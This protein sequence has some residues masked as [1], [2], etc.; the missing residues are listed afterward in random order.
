MAFFSYTVQ[1]TI[2]GNFH[3]VSVLCGS[4]IEKFKEIPYF[5]YYILATTPKNNPKVLLI[6]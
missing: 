2:A 6:S 5:I 4:D 1:S 3:T